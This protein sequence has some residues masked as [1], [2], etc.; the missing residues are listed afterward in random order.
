MSLP[1]YRCLCCLE[2]FFGEMGREGW[3]REVIHH[4]ADGSLGR[5]LYADLPADPG[6][7]ASSSTENPK[8][9]PSP[10]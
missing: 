6:A 3:P 4:C 5:A 8:P 7:A 9:S 10:S 1:R 2:V